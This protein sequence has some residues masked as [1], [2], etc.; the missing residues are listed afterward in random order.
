MD[1]KQTLDLMEGYLNEANAE[2]AAGTHRGLVLVWASIIDDILLKMLKEHF[3]QLN[4]S[5][6]D[7]LF[8]PMGPLGG[9]SNR[10]KLLHAL[11]II[12]RD[13]M[14]AIDELRSIRNKFAHKLGLSLDDDELAETCNS[15]GATLT[16]S[17]ESTPMLNFGSGCASLLMLL[18][19]RWSLITKTA[20]IPDDRDLPDRAYGVPGGDKKN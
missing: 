1:A 6:R 9:F 12:K 3:V 10:T 4:S 16:G 5:Q 20:G 19:N 18:I 15:F 14:Q 8:G 7:D 13:E 2:N 11:G 17:N